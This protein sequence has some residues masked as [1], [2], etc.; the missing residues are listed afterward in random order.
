MNGTSIG[1]NIRKRR[2]EMGITQE[3]LAEM[4]G[5]STSYIGAIERGEKLP[6]LTVFIRI[7]NALEVSSDRLLSGVLTVGNEVVA[8]ELSMRIARIPGEE[9]RRILRVVQAMLED[10]E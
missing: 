4:V 2:D 6:K 5:L 3:A 1:Q 9:Q 8:S 7:A 10:Y